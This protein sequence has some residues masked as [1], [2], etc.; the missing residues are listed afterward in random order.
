LCR[1]I[2]LLGLVKI[3]LLAGL[4][5]L[6]VDEDIN[7][8]MQSDRAIIAKGMLAVAATPFSTNKPVT[9]DLPTPP[10]DNAP[11]FLPPPPVRP[12]APSPFAQQN[13]EYTRPDEVT[14]P[15]AP[16]PPSVI[17][18][19]PKDSAQRKQEEI[20]RR[21]H[22]L[23]S[24]Q[25]Q[26]QSRLDEMKSIEGKV[27]TMIKDVDNSQDD[28]LKHLIDVYSNMKAKQAAQVMSTVEERLAVR[29][30]AG[31]RGRQAGEILTYMDPVKA[32]KISEAL[33]RTQLPQH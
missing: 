14:P 1:W 30:L 18:V 16:P 19:A 27:Q 26:M 24:L 21:E 20:N 22:E 4:V 32:A 6:P 10:K 8:T 23:L 33:T 12:A 3:S 29:I 7:L 31:M 5:I 15:S 9:P 2:I 25:D 17:P 11:A 13:V 28:R